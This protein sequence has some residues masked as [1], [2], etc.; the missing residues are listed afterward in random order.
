MPWNP[1]S[2]S[3]KRGTRLKAPKTGLLHWS[4]ALQL[5]SENITGKLETMAKETSPMEGKLGTT[6]SDADK[7]SS[8]NWLL[9][10]SWRSQHGSLPKNKQTPFQPANKR[11]S[12]PSKAREREKNRWD[13]MSPE[14]NDTIGYRLGT[15]VLLRSQTG[16]TNASSSCIALMWILLSC[17]K[18]S[19][20]HPGNHKD[21]V[22][23]LAHILEEQLHACQLRH[24]SQKRSCEKLLSPKTGVRH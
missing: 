9:F 14:P 12:S 13:L 3:S 2:G 15:Q 18:K 17:L 4:T 6:G 11:T 24:S 5:P 21:L 8:M 16:L 20:P 7:D 22:G 23:P 1:K 19:T 10:S